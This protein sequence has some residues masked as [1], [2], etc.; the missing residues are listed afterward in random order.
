MLIDRLPSESA[1]KTA[2][3]D[4]I[5]AVEL[6][7]QAAEDA[8]KPDLGDAPIRL[9]PYSQ[10]DMLMAQLI[11]EIRWTRYAVYHAQGGKPHK[12]TQYP[13]PGV[14]PAGTKSLQ[15][16]QRDYLTAIKERRPQ[17]D[18]PAVPEH[19]AASKP[20]KL[21]PAER[22]WLLQQI[23]AARAGQPAPPAPASL[24]GGAG[25]T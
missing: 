13:R 11:D 16:D 25:H 24:S 19:L 2:I 6:A 17:R 14:A 3:R 23:A 5:G 12:P 21:G 7:R 10:T 22:H 4:D 20:K 8:E 15:P 9:G 1:T 18:M